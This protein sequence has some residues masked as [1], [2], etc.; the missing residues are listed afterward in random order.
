M[1]PARFNARLCGISAGTPRLNRVCNHVTHRHGTRYSQRCLSKR[2]STE[3]NHIDR[4]ASTILNSTQREAVGEALSLVAMRHART[5][6]WQVV[7][8]I[9]ACIKP[10]MRNRRPMRWDRACS[11]N[12]GWTAYGIR[13]SS[14]SGK[15]RCA[16]ARRARSPIR[17][18]PATTSSSSISAPSGP[19]TKATQARPSFAAMIRTCMRACAQAARVIFDEVEHR[20]RTEVAALTKTVPR[21][22]ASSASASGHRAAR[23]SHARSPVPRRSAVP[24]SRGGSCAAQ[25]LRRSPVSTPIMY[26]ACPAFDMRGRPRPH[27]SR[28]RGWPGVCLNGRATASLDVCK[29]A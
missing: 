20:W 19:R 4:Y 12:S 21:R 1:L 26:Q 16:R 9:A 27:M 18:A 10:G 29:G 24:P 17:Y 13:S 15:T 8:A 3:P 11:R 2:R 25:R 7:D 23:A 6:T 5:M 14:A 22:A 28:A